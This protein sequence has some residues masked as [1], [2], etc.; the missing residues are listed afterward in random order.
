M[1]DGRLVKVTISGGIASMPAGRPLPSG[2]LDATIK[3]A[4]KRLYEAKQQGRNR[5]VCEAPIA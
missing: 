2:I 5:I 1:T 4:D 3:S